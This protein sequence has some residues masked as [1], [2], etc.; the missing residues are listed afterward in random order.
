MT[1][2]LERFQNERAIIYINQVTILADVTFPSIP[3]VI[4][5]RD[6][7]KMD[8]ARAEPS[9]GYPVV[10]VTVSKRAGPNR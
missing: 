2:R 9:P 10:C 4:S 5:L 8:K 7:D 6:Y 3:S 1:F